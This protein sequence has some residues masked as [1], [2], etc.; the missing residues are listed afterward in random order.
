MAAIFHLHVSGCW[1]FLITMFDTPEVGSEHCFRSTSVALELVASQRVQGTQ[2]TVIVTW[3]AFVL[4]VQE[5]S[6]GTGSVTPD[7][8]QPVPSEVALSTVG[9]RVAFST[10]FDTR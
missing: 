8:R 5:V 10:A 7:R 3:F 2:G 4:E 9:E 6:V 1:S